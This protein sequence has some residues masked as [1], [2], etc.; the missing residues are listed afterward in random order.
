MPGRGRPGPRRPGRWA[1][2]MLLFDLDRGAGLGPALAQRLDVPIAAHEERVFA[3]GECKLRPLADPGGADVYIVHSLHGGPDAS[4]HDKLFKLLGFIA[5]VKAH[6]ARRV[7]AVVPYLA[8]ARKD[9]R[10]QPLDPLGVRCVAQLFEAVGTD[11]LMV[12][13]VHNVA[14][15]ENAFRCRTQHLP[16]HPCFAEVARAQSAARPLVVASPDPG[17]VKRVQLWREALEAT[18]SRPV[19][20]SMVDKRRSAD[21]V[22]GGELVA[23]HV[24]GAS[25]LLLDDLIASGD[26]M[27]RAARALRAAGAAS[28][29]ACAAHGLFVGEA[30]RLLMED[31]IDSIVVS[32][33]V[34]T[35]RIAADD[36]LR[37]KLRVLSCAGALAAAIRRSRQ[38][39]R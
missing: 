18:L 20:M 8:Y 38:A 16:V 31:S 6:G 26:T 3:D 7:S 25:V 13:E 19:G 22:S 30:A 34:P 39:W 17:G 9:R 32:D 27:V 5:T 14:A 33:S 29:T 24:S 28:V 21:V 2:A 15:F 23:G 36:P 1:E 37:G 35:F 12:L 11:Q 10:T 4:P